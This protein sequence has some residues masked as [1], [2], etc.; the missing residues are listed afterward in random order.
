[1][2]TQTKNTKLR[3]EAKL[4][5]WNYYQENKSTLPTWIRE[6]REE[7][8]EKLIDGDSVNTVFST[9]IESVQ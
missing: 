9:I 6:C 5:M 8:L 3:E 2:S 4:V 1:M 7:I